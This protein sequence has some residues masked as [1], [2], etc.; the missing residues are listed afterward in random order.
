MF[1]TVFANLFYE[2]NNPGLDAAGSNLKCAVYGDI[3]TAAEKTNKG[4][5]QLAALPAGTTYIQQSSGYSSGSLVS[6]APPEGYDLVF[7]PTNGAN[8][9]P[10]VSQ[11]F[12]AFWCI[13]PRT[14][15]ASVTSTWALRSSTDTT[16][17]LVPHCVTPVDQIAWVELASTSIFGAQ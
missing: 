11:C 14:K 3:H 9:A 15:L 12:F 13:S 7:G 6:P 17:T 1:P 2:F 4:G 16:S 8:N 5:Q 10:G